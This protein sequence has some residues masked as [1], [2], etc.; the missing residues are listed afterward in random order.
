MGRYYGTESGK[1]N[2]H[3]QLTDIETFRAS[4]AI[5]TCCGEL[6]DN[7]AGNEKCLICGEET[8]VKTGWWAWTCFPGCLP[9]SDPLGPF[10]RES[11]ALKEYREMAGLS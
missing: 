8:E 5:C 11:E 1:P 2:D 6:H 4:Y 3:F 10:P 7:E 9:D